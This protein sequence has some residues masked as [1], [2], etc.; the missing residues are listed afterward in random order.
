MLGVLGQ[1]LVDAQR[2]LTAV[3][4]Q[5]QVLIQLLTIGMVQVFA[6]QFVKLVFYQFFFVIHSAVV[7]RL[8]CHFRIQVH[9]L[10]VVFLHRLFTRQEVVITVKGLV[11]AK[12]VAKG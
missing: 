1:V 2:L 4:L 11:I 12:F 10:E 5:P 6:L 7:S 9:G 8:F 3:Y